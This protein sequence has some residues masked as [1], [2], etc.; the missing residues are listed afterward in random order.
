VTYGSLFSGIGGIDLGLDRAGMECRWQVEINQFCLDVLEKHWP[1]VP[2]Y[3][4]IRTISGDSL[5]RVDLICGGFPCQPISLAGRRKGSADDRWLWPDFL[6][7]LQEHKPEYVF[8]ENVRGLISNGMVS[9]V[10][11]LS[12]LGYD[13]EWHCIPASS[14]GA[15]HKR[16]RIFI[17]AYPN[18]KWREAIFQPNPRDGGPLQG[19]ACERPRGDSG[20]DLSR[21]W[22]DSAPL[23]NGKVYKPGVPLLADGVPAAVERIGSF[24]NAVVPQVVE[25]I[26]RSLM[27]AV[28]SYVQ[29]NSYE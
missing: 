19:K 1:D 22:A 2:R 18:G 28:S 10:E 27:A 4:D 21:F 6:R 17:L 25:L 26:G 8:I 29:T 20:L 24:G 16:E 7:I 12:S 23:E 14:V 15:P 13:S 3:R 9:I 11:G 5:P